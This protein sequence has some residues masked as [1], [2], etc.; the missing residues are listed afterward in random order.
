MVY[1]LNGLFPNLVTSARLVAVYFIIRLP[2]DWNDESNLRLLFILMIIAEISDWLD[3]L[4][5]RSKLGRVTKFG[6]IF[7]PVSDSIYHQL[8]FIA[9]AIQGWMS[10]WPYI[11]IFLPRELLSY[12][13]RFVMGWYGQKLGA[14]QS[15][16]WKAR[17]QAFAQ[18][19]M[20]GSYL[21]FPYV[22]LSRDL[23][24]NLSLT[25]IIVAA[26]VAIWSG[27][28]YTLHAKRSVSKA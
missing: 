11:L 19:F 17:L 20:V 15:G 7:D 23:A 26:L 22:E 10:W 16:K 5:A 1:F 24:T 28:D 4:A 18:L 9:F 3:G 2:G 8:M 6:E 27:V 12:I 25:A 21:L 14:R 13:Y